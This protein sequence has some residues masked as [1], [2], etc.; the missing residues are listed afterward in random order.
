MGLYP[1]SDLFDLALFFY[2]YFKLCMILGKISQRVF[3]RISGG[4]L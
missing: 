4:G 2:V 1:L 3:I